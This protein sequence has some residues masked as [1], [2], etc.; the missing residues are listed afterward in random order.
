MRPPL[1]RPTLAMGS[2]VAKWTTSSTSRLSYGWPQRSTGSWIMSVHPNG[3]GCRER[4][5]RTD[6]ADAIPRVA[7]IRRLPFA[8]ITLEKSR[9][10]EFFGQC[11]DLHAAGL[12]VFHKL[13]GVVEIHD[14]NDGARLRRVVGDFVIVVRPAWRA[15]GETHEGIAVGGRHKR[16]V[17]QLF[18]CKSIPVRRELRAA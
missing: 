16:A 11:S 3:C 15:R 18:L 7:L 9:H 6:A 1:A 13:I 8:F 10:E 17:Q 4:A 12:A 5:I 14:L 2:P